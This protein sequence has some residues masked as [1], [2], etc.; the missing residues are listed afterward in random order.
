MSIITTAGKIVAKTVAVKI[1]KVIYKRGGTTML[2]VISLVTT[3]IF[4]Y[5]LFSK[6][7]DE[8]EQKLIENK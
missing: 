3:G 5:K 7:G 2:G 4:L 6:D 8:E 1:G